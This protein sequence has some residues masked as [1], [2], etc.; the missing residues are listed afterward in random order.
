M[1]PMHVM[2][3]AIAALGIVGASIAASGRT[4]S[5]PKEGAHPVHQFR[6]G[7]KCDLTL[8]DQGRLAEACTSTKTRP[9]PRE[10]DG[11]TKPRRSR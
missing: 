5:A 6:T 10:R 1:K 8:L 2:L 4:G 7:T 3:T 11:L 9:P